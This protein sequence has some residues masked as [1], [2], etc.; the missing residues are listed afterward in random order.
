MLKLVFSFL[1][2]LASNFRVLFS[3]HVDDRSHAVN[4]IC[5]QEQ[6]VHF[7]S[8]IKCLVSKKPLPGNSRLLPLYP[9][10]E[11]GLLKVGGRLAHG[12]LVSD[13]MKF[14]I[15]L[16]KESCFSTLLVQDV[17]IRYLHC[18]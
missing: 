17:H 18:G 4:F 9:W 2:K 5:A 15:I 16:P 8:E 3:E 6:Q 13:D 11:D 10:L 12:D 7:A 1:R 14:P